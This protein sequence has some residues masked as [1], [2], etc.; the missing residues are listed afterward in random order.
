MAEQFEVT[1]DKLRDTLRESLETADKRQEDISR[2]QQEQK[3]QV[4]FLVCL[5]SGL[6]GQ[7]NCIRIV[8]HPQ[9]GCFDA[10]WASHSDDSH[11]RV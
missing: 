5:I 9:S 2:W 4:L 3:Y 8:P 7:Y 6:F 11:Q 1:L 10:H